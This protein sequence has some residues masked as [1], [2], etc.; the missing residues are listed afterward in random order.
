M[1]NSHIKFETEIKCGD[2]TLKLCQLTNEQLVRM[3]N[4]LIEVEPYERRKEQFEVL[5]PDM[6]KIAYE[7]AKQESKDRAEG[8]GFDN[9]F[10]SYANLVYVV[11]L[12]AKKH[13]PEMTREKIINMFDDKDFQ[14]R[15]IE[16]FPRLLNNEQSD[17]KK[18]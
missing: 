4:Y 7:E 2:T 5:P 15:I 17:E 16:I 10:T 6:K 11:T 3:Q 13:H 14:E 18:V 12:A 9:V 1:S 8:K